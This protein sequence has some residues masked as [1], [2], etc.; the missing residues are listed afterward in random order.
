M[1]GREA[2]VVAVDE[3]PANPTPGMRVLVYVRQKK[4]LRMVMVRHSTGGWRLSRGVRSEGYVHTL[5]S[6]D[7]GA[8]RT[9]DAMRVL[10]GAWL[11]FK[12]E[13][14]RETA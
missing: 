11:M 1:R 12:M 4:D 2:N 9:K 10:D 7:L 6:E 8:M 13:H 3:L 14:A 5:Q